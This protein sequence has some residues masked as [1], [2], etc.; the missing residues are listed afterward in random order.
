MLINDVE[1]TINKYN[2]IAKNDKIVVA[3]SGGPDSMCLLNVLI[4]LKDKYLFEL[5]VA[6]VNHS[7]RAVADEETE[8]VKEF[9]EKNNIECFIKKVDVIKIAE[10]QKISTEEAGRNI[11]YD[12]FEEVFCKVNA[13][14][15]AVAH[16]KNDNCET[17]FMNLIRGT[18][19]S[20][21]KG[22]DPIRS[23]KYIRPLIEI[24]RKDI[25]E[26]CDFKHLNPKID[27]SNF[28]NVYTRNKI[29]NILIPFIEK[30]LNPNIIDTIDRLSVLAKQENE[31]V[32]FMVDRGFK[33]VLI[34]EHQN[35]IELNLKKYNSLDYF[36]K[37]KVFMLCIKKLFNNTKGI[38][39]IHVE[40]V[41]KLCNNNVGNKYLTPNK[42]TKVMVNKGIIS[43]LKIK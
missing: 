24:S 17:V 36:I 27:E 6:H 21:L 10:K 35:C 8:Y 33:S 39:K 14:K 9:C 41:I 42:N 20:G 5:V 26:Y 3:V 22:I 19:I 30:E 32:D 34:N 2:M 25:E 12:F 15:I 4:E 1:N 40:D 38:E 43:I 28:E 7:I 16:N 11:R 18:G 37:S 13:T 23:N 31:Y 29:R